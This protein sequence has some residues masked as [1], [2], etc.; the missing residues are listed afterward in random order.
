MAECAALDA[1]QLQ[2]AL[3]ALSD[4]HPVLCQRFEEQAGVIQRIAGKPCQLEVV[5]LDSDDQ[6]EVERY[7]AQC[8]NKAFD[9][10]CDC[11]LRVTLINS[12]SRH[13]IALSAHHI[14]LDGW[15]LNK[16][17]ND[18][19]V[20]YEGGE[21]AV[22]EPFALDYNDYCYQQTNWMQSAEAQ[23]QRAFWQAYL[24][25][26]NE[27]VSL[28]VDHQKRPERNPVAAYYD[29]NLEASVV[30]QIEQLASRYAVTPFNLYLC[31]F[32]LALSHASGERDLVIGTVS[33]GRTQ[34]GFEQTL[35]MFVN[36]LSYRQRYSPQMRFVDLIKQSGHEFGAMMANQMLPYDEV[37]SALSRGGQ[38]P[39]FNVM[40]DLQNSFS[41][42]SLQ[43][44]GQ[45]LTL[46]DLPAD[47]P[48]F[49]MTVVLE[50]LPQG[51]RLRFEYDATLYEPETIARFAHKYLSL[52]QQASA[53]PEQVIAEFELLDQ[54]DSRIWHDFATLPATQHR[55][56]HYLDVFDE[57][58]AQYGDKIAV[59]DGQRSLT[60]RELD[61]EANRLA[62]VLLQQGAV[63]DHPIAVHLTRSC[64]VMIAMLAIFKAGGCYLPL[65]TRLPTER[66]RMLLDE[67]HIK[68]VITDRAG[69]FDDVCVVHPNDRATQNVDLSAV[70]RHPEQL[71]Y[72]LF[73]SGTTGKPKGAMTTHQGMV[74]HNWAALDT[75]KFSAV[76]TFAQTAALSF[77]ISVWQYLGALM[78]GGCVA[79]FSD[80][81][82]LDP[83]L[84]LQALTRH[85]VS[86][87]QT[88]PV[89]LQQLMDEVA[90]G[91]YD[92]LGDL[93]HLIPTGE[94]LPPEMARRWFKRY[95]HIPM[96]NAYGPAECSD[97]V[98]LH[99]MKETPAAF[100]AQLPIG[101][102]V[103]Q[104]AIYLLDADLL[105]VPQG[106]VGRSVLQVR[107][108]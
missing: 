47:Q 104:S 100:Y 46:L 35:G 39:L 31:A 36:T 63:A 60:Y 12:Q 28:P 6:H 4:M 90:A 25:Q 18:L 55:N 54:G 96:M 70:V 3:I 13:F 65:D 11:P 62:G 2:Q 15:S 64:H 78:K 88:V 108:Y 9:L 42:D 7:A 91:A 16:L 84:F 66:I 61:G 103:Y 81:T 93:R 27:G 86:V 34:S 19:A 38:S 68:Q 92:S 85:Q 94:A 106:A 75:L 57:V 23:A 67:H 52:L 80:E 5:E 32:S 26:A 99:V 72:V 76:D 40:F 30:A 50:S 1:K 79:I 41:S 20:A 44:A 22:A 105:P 24:E 82:V 102:P 33:A 107:W 45:P 53:K 83:L 49:D 37:M 71:A 17:F 58:V 98:T 89:Q 10:A 8:V 73:T 77:D 69:P 21:L 56:A 14:A 97:D 59:D 101:K 74:N 87:L 95:P 29:I 51:T 43:L 48:Q